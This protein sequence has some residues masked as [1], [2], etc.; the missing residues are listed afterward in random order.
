MRTTTSVTGLLALT[1]LAPAAA[2]TLSKR[3]A[4]R[5][6]YRFTNGTFIEN[7]AVRPNGH[8]LLSTFANASLF[9]LDPLSPEDPLPPPRY[10]G[11]VPDITGLTGLAQV[12]PDVW[13]VSGGVS[14][15]E[16]YAF[17][18]GTAVVS[19]FD[20]QG[21][22]PSE[23]NEGGVPAEIVARVPDAAM[24][25]GMT[26]LAA[27]PHIVLSAGSKTGSI[28]RIDTRTGAVDEA[29]QDDVLAPYSPEFKR[30]PLGV[31]GVH[32][33]GDY[34]Y[35]TNS[36]KA[37]FGRVPVDEQGGRAGDIEI[38]NTMADDDTHAYDDFSV[39]AE[40]AGMVYVGKQKDSVVGIS[41]EHG[42]AEVLLG[43]DSPIVVEMPTSTALSL[44]GKTLY[45]VTGGGQVIA[46]EL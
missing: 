14:D 43:P 5:E 42:R 26:N 8:L 2:N 23:G 33:A 25:N 29:F 18:E 7:V 11:S 27:N 46:Y 12:A 45:I 39:A 36:D 32:I 19:L 35:F 34:L 37:F 13:A 30:A 4:A 1:Q 44:D 9:T 21:W 17:V 28:I 3:G 10:V 16:N 22:A 6:L 41:T 20:L 15:I 40:E 38:I 24:L 31:N